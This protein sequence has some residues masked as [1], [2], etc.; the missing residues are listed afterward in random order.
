MELRGF[1]AISPREIAVRV[2]TAGALPGKDWL[3]GSNA[4]IDW[5]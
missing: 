5:F 4:F 1:E 2:E 3:A